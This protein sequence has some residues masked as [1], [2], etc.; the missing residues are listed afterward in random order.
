MHRS[1]EDA[2]SAD[3]DGVPCGILHFRFLEDQDLASL[4]S[5]CSISNV[6]CTSNCRDGIITAKNRYSCC[7]RSVYFNSTGA[8]ASSYLSLSV[9]RSCNIDLPGTC[10]A[11]SS[12]VSLMEENIN[13]TTLIITG[14]MCL[15]LIMHS[16]IM[17]A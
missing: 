9:L 15:Q 3:T 2:C 11:I 16:I 12:A 1:I 4:G 7:L 13:Y 14:L 17:T 6:S 8:V 10:G 5:A